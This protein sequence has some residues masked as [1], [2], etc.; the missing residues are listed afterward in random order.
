MSSCWV[1]LGGNNSQTPWL[2]TITLIFSMWNSGL[3]SKN[4]FVYL[5]AMCTDQMMIKCSHTWTLKTHSLG[6]MDHMLALRF[7]LCLFSQKRIG[8]F[9]GMCALAWGFVLCFGYSKHRAWNLKELHEL[10]VLQME[11]TK[12]AESWCKWVALVYLLLDKCNL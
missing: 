4:T 10:D 7:S 8:W 12:A 11:V 6:W 1:L 9:C 3:A 2:G 5:H